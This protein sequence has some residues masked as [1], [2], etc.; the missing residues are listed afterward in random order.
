MKTR[1]IEKKE[2]CALRSVL[3]ER[4]WLPFWV[5][6]ETGLRIGD[7]LSLRPFM[8][9][10]GEIRYKAR[11]TGKTGT[12]FI[13]SDLEA[14]LTK[15]GHGSEWVFPSPKDSEKHLTRQAAWARLKRAAEK[16]GISGRGVAP[17][18][19]RK[20]FA[21]ELLKVSTLNDVAAALQH[22]RTD[23]TEIYALSDWSSGEHSNEPLLRGDLPKIVEKIFEIIGYRLDN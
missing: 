20:N 18:S 14:A 23:T 1:Y 19:M 22:E 10:G 12:A 17:H 11:K 16:A 9:G 3:S 6:L 4:E 21:V 15:S 8:V 2:V 5:M 7:V 13:S